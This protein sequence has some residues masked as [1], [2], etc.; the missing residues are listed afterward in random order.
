MNEILFFNAVNF[1]F[2]LQNK[3][4]GLWTVKTEFF[5]TS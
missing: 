5:F 2:L 1:G 4:T 3:L